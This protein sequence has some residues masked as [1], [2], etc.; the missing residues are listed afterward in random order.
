MKS[1]NL[2]MAFGGVVSLAIAVTAAGQDT[3]P[4]DCDCAGER[5]PLVD[6]LTAPFDSGLVAACTNY[7]SYATGEAVWLVD[8]GNQGSAPLGSNW[9]TD[10]YSHPTWTMEN[11]GGVFGVTL[12]DVGN[13]FCR[14]P[15]GKGAC[16]R[17]R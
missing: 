10:R 12:D 16:D 9:A 17:A 14:A 1:A 3:P 6:N 13:I 5:P 15:V 7:F 4:I 2:W 8:L 11:L